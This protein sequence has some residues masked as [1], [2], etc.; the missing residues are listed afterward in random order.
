M[1]PEYDEEAVEAV[2]E[3]MQA[4]ERK[5]ILAHPTLKT[6]ANWYAQKAEAYKRKACN[7]HQSKTRQELSE[8]GGKATKKI[9]QRIDKLPA[10]A[11]MYLKMDREGFRGQAEGTFTT[12]PREIDG[13]I[14]RAC[15]TIYDGTKGQ[16][17]GSS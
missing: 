10:Q 11:I 16:G 7:A 14:K 2:Q 17:S 9:V 6:V 5:D 12:E 13:I 3:A 4:H 8:K 15:Q 1:T